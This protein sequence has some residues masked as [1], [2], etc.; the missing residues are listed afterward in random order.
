MDPI[1]RPRMR[2]VLICNQQVG[3]SIPSSGT[4]KTPAKSRTWRGFRDEEQK[5]TSNSEGANCPTF[6][7]GLFS[8]GAVGA[9]SLFLLI[10]SAIMSSQ[11]ARYQPTC[12]NAPS[13]RGN[14]FGIK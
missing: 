1:E 8:M 5:R 11:M 2:G 14:F 12:I 10:A 3:G 13:S 4:T 6:Y 7:A 9:V